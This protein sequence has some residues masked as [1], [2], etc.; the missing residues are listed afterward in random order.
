[1]TRRRKRS[2]RGVEAVIDKDRASALLARDLDADRFVMA[3]DADA[4]Y[5]GWGTPAQ[6]AIARAGPEALAD[7]SFAEG[8]MGPKVG[9]ACDFVRRTGHRAV[10]GPLED[11]GQ[12]VLGRA[13]TVIELGD[14]LVLRTVGGGS[15]Q[16]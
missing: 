16:L 10:I 13:G 6:R 11:L 12:M 7:H 3:T 15:S 9:A 14:H 5:L 4:V 2:L 1:M 8:S